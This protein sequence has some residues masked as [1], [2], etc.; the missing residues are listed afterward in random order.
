MRRFNHKSLQFSVI[1][2]IRKRLE[3]K[4][5]TAPILAMDSRR[6]TS[7]TTESIPTKHD[8]ERSHN[9]VVTKD[10]WIIRHGQAVHNPRAEYARDVLQCSHEEFLSIMEQDDCFDAPL[11]SLGIQQ[12]QQLYTQYSESHWYY[13]TPIL[14]EIDQLEESTSILES[15]T[16][17]Q[18]ELVV[19]S[20][21]SRALRTAELALGDMNHDDNNSNNS[22]HQNTTKI[23]CTNRV[24]YEGFREINGWLQNAKRHTKIELETKFPTWDFSLLSSSNDDDQW[25]PTLETTD[26][27]M[28][29][30]YNG[31]LWILKERPE[32]SIVL[33]S[34]GA[35]LMYTLT[36]HPNVILQDG[37]KRITAQQ[38]QPQR[39][40]TNGSNMET[41]ISTDEEQQQQQH[42]CVRKRYHNCEI[43]RYRMELS[44][45][46][47]SCGHE[48][49]DDD[50]PNDT[51]VD[52]QVQQLREVIVLTEVDL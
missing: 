3:G 36:S 14:H 45:P 44:L 52:D 47:Q 4:V 7:S 9:V 28:E 18:V 8:I 21:L 49:D 31:L 12:A 20:P 48:D 32:R 34:H 24:C 40:A 5:S 29:R 17:H 39:D 37:R 11:T 42:R 26:S 22:N 38:Q 13:Q 10:I 15:K 35:L 41:N 16:R 46:K 23:T 30:G 51:A 50:I 6:M 19:S 25:T 1:K 33:V 2:N 43:R 27:C